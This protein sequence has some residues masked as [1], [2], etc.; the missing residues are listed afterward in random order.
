MID[1]ALIWSAFASRERPASTVEH[2]RGDFLEVDA[3]HFEGLDRC[4]VTARDWIDHSDAFFG[5]SPDGFIYFLPSLLIASL[6]EAETSLIAADALVS[7]LDT[8]ADPNLWDAW[9]VARFS[10]LN[11]AELKAIRGWSERRLCGV[12]RDMATEHGRVRDTIDMLTLMQ[13]R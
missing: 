6:D 3:R 12:D 8:S 11:A 10:R 5:L 13:E 1:A 9:F 7:V 4:R 2:R